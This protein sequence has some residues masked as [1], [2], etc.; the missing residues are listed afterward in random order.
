MPYD[1][2]E[3]LVGQLLEGVGYKNVQVTAR[4]P[5]GGVDLTA[6]ATV[7]LGIVRVLVQAKRQKRNVP[8]DVVRALRGCL[9]PGDHGIVITTAS[10]TSAARKAAGENGRVPIWLVDSTQVFD[11]LVEQGIGVSKRRPML[12]ELVAAN[13]PISVSPEKREE[14]L[15]HDPLAYQPRYTRTPRGRTIEIPISA[16]FAGQRAALLPIFSA[17][18]GAAL[19]ACPDV[20]Y[21]A[22]RQH[23]VFAVGTEHHRSVAMLVQVQGKRLAIYL[24]LPRETST[25]PR[26]L[27]YRDKGWYTLGYKVYLGV[28]G[29]VDN[30]LR[31]WLEQAFRDH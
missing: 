13:V 17:L 16:H 15:A 31:S 22:I 5:D 8:V 18:A 12:L 14:A 24:R 2:F 27:S 21:F 6:E 28:P 9:A 3:A 20:D 4:G 29:D 25:T 30:E 11:M 23:I 1:A 19:H 10:F 7:K 26:L